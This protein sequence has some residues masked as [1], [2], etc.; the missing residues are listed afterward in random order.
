MSMFRTITYFYVAQVMMLILVD[1]ALNEPNA[2]L[3]F[4]WGRSNEKKT[5]VSIWDLSCLFS[6]LQV[7]FSLDP[8]VTML[9]L[10]G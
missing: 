4:V 3:L 6:L 10:L 5:L 2:V 8:S 1:V 9:F 7:I